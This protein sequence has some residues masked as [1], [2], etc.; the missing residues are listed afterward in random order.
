VDTVISVSRPP[1][2]VAACQAKLASMRERCEALA[3]EREAPSQAASPAVLALARLLDDQGV[4]GAPVPGCRDSKGELRTPECLRLRGSE[5]AVVALTVYNAGQE[6]WA[7]VQATL[8]PTAGGEPRIIRALLPLQAAIAPG[9]AVRVAVEVAMPRRRKGCWFS[10]S[11]T[12]T[13]C[14]SAGAC[15]SIQDV[16]L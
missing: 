9:E 5:W 3:R 4:L 12:L 1:Q 14:D 11:H 15:L 2:S 13:V 16:R 7:P 8:R 6:P 10:E